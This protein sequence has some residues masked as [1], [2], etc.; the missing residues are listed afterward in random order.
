MKK[1]IKVKKE[2]NTLDSIV[3]FVNS[4][5]PYECKKDYDIWDVRSDVNG[6]MEQC[7]VI[8]QSS[9]NG[10]KVHFDQDSILVMSHIVPSKVMNAYFGKSVKRHRNILE[11]VTGKIGEA[12]FSRSR[13]KSFSEIEQIINKMGEV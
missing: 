8:K 6:Q 13:K 10:M 5:S 3:A 2:F 9:M 12:I 1:E 11:V 4:E 7:V